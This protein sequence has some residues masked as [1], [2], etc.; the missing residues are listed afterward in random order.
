MKSFLTS[1]I[2]R[3]MKI[4]SIIL[5]KDI[6]WLPISRK[7]KGAHL[8]TTQSRST[9]KSDPATTLPGPT[10]LT[11]FLGFQGKC[12]TLKDGISVAVIPKDPH[13]H[14]LPQQT[15]RFLVASA[16]LF[17]TFLSALFTPE[18]IISR[19]F[20][21]FI[22]ACIYTGGNLPDVNMMLKRSWVASV[23]Q[24]TSHKVFAKVKWVTELQ[25]FGGWKGSFK[26]LVFSKF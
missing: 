22:W 11:L 24:D 19:V 9:P 18:N 12:W 4:K 2:I 23:W 1:L 8:E 16:S 14:S 15:K 13:L 5:L 3:K 17:C 20:K 10:P 21:S 6:R 7:T 26:L 25:W